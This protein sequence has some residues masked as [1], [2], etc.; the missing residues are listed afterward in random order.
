MRPLTRISTT[1][2]EV[3]SIRLERSLKDKLK[4]LSGSR[5]YQSLIRDILWNYVQNKSGEYRSEFTTKDIRATVDAI[6]QKDE[7]CV[8]TGQLIQ[9]GQPMYLGLTI[10]GDFVPLSLGSIDEAA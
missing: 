4:K 8:L 10:F 1:E 7:S 5:G 6:A 9:E 2:M 3:T